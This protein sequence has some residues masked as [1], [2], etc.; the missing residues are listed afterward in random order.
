MVADFKE[1]RGVDPRAVWAEA[2]EDARRPLVALFSSKRKSEAAVAAAARTTSPAEVGAPAAAVGAGGRD[3]GG[4][5]AA[6]TAAA[7]V[8]VGDI[9]AAQECLQAVAELVQPGMVRGTNTVLYCALPVLNSALCARVD[10]IFLRQARCLPRRSRPAA[11]PQRGNGMRRQR[12]CSSWRRRKRS[13]R[14]CG[15]PSSPPRYDPLRCHKLP[16]CQELI[17]T[18]H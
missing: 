14:R 3:E 13:W 8:A 9:A 7:K 6:A 1:K 12:Q 11:A 2:P 4:A 16:R 5:S 17:H 15:A 10:R 18:T